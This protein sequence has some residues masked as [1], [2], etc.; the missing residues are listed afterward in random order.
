MPALRS[1]RSN[2]LITAEEKEWAL[3]THIR[4]SQGNMYH[5]EIKALKSRSSIDSSCKL[6]PLNPIL[7]EEGILRVGGRLTNSEL[8]YEQKHPIILAYTCPLAKLLVADAHKCC[9]HGGIQEM[10]QYLRMRFWILHARRIVKSYLHQCVV[11]RRHSRITH[12]QQMSSLPK[13]RVMVAPPFTHTGLDYCGPFNVRH[14][15]KRST[16]MTKTYGAIFICMA[17]KAVHIELAEDL[18][19]QAF[20]DVFDRFISRL[21]IC[22]VLYSDNGTQFVGASRVMNQDLQ[23]WRNI[24][25]TQHIASSGTQWKFITPAAPHH[26][27][28]WEAAVHSAKKHLY[29]TIG[30]QILR[31][32]QLST[33]LVRIEACLNSRPLV[34][35][36]DDPSG[37]YAL[38]PGDFL[39]GRPLNSRP[40][41]P[42]VDVPKNRL[43][44]SQ[45]LQQMF[46]HFW[47]RWNYEYLSTLQARR[48]WESRRQNLQ[49]GD[50][51]LILNEN[52]PPTHWR[53]GRITKV[54]P[55]SDGLVR[56][57]TVE[58]N[59]DKRT[60]EGLFVKHY[61]QRPVQKICRLID[62]NQEVLNLE[63]SAGE[64]C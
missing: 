37:S 5:S 34:P 10:L 45:Q 43:L 9:L 33:L 60:T 35:L 40:E 59:S 24:Y 8:P 55:G 19:S 26:G 7:D 41:P 16:T 11:C 3:I 23:S 49:E 30:R 2:E 51:V 61:C 25:A 1:Q 28:L 22:S 29:R 20:I 12:Q 53:I 14:G 17:T 31:F 62:P 13:S 21:G 64:E 15:G 6:L 57:V 50:V 32:N 27:G 54:H 36:H 38:T 47:K 56:I 44:Y 4:Q 46:E 58:Y 39:I 42:V 63:G 48:K 52:L 18:S